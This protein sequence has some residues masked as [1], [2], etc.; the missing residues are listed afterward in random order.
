MDTKY[1]SKG[2]M[3]KFTYSFLKFLFV[4]HE[5]ICFVEHLLDFSFQSFLLS[6]VGTLCWA[7][8]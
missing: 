7:R 2:D 5:V 1:V 6:L 4:D 3:K 8:S